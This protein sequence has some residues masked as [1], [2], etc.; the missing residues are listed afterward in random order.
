MERSQ[1]G[2]HKS[3]LARLTRLTLC[4]K[5][6]HGLVR[7]AP[8][9]SSLSGRRDLNP[10]PQHPDCCALAWLRY[11]PQLPEVLSRPPLARCVGYTDCSILSSPKHECCDHNWR[12]GARS[13]KSDTVCSFKLLR[14]SD[15]IS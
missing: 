8:I 11:A 4:N 12:L 13:S 15:L 5:K 2:G 9:S 1:G 7:R 10:G 3:R 6:G 14:P